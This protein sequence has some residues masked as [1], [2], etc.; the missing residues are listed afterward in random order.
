VDIRPAHITVQIKGR[1]P[2]LDAP[3]HKR[4]RSGE[5][6]STWTIG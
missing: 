2:F 1:A 6:E 4:I 3:L 5:D